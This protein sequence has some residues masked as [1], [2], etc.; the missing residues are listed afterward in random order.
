[1]AHSG[2][3]VAVITAGLDFAHH[4]HCNVIIFNNYCRYSLV[5]V[6][7]LCCVVLY[8]IVLQNACGNI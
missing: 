1:M 3:G 4:G 2:V 5:Y 8:C 6:H 7:V